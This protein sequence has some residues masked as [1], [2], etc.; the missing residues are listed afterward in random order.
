MKIPTLFFFTL[1]L[2]T[3]L[4]FSCTDDK[5][6]KPLVLHKIIGE[7]ENCTCEPFINEYVWQNKTV[8]V[9]AF[10]G[11]ACNTI[12]AYYNEN[13]TEFTMDEGYTYMEFIEDS[14]LVGNVWTCQE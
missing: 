9:M 10:K 8:Y 12:P 7:V 6:E 4:V 3:C 5:P 13:G 2:L 14:V 1:C 11:P